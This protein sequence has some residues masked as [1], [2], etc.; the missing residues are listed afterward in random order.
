MTNFQ[1]TCSEL[2]Y[3]NCNIC[4]SDN[5][6]LLGVENNCNIC[7]C[8][9]CGLIYVNPRPVSQSLSPDFFDN[10]DEPPEE[11]W[12]AKNY[13]NYLEILDTIEQ[14]CPDKGR[15]LDVGC[16][17]GF[18]LNLARERGWQIFGEDTSLSAV[19][20][21]HKQ[22]NINVFRGLLEEADFPDNYFNA[23]MLW[24]VLEHL[25][26]PQSTLKEI[27]RIMAPNA[28]LIVRVPNVNFILIKSKA[29]GKRS[30]VDGAPHHLFGF[31]PQTLNLMLKNIFVKEVKIFPGKI[32]EMMLKDFIKIPFAPMATSIA[33]ILLNAAFKLNQRCFF[34]PSIMAMA[35]K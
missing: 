10:F 5:T 30:I 31:T 14:V 3:V 22:L 28:V 12:G 24:L 9:Q 27:Y 19:S 21:C 34:S 4:G 26:D 23:V 29:S 17:Y 2:K 18:F 20:Y 33:N 35:I 16:G 6:Q 1:S 32:N 7:L 15:L 8:R 11:R 25:P 13:K